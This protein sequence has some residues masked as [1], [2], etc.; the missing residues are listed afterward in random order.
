MATKNITPNQVNDI[1]KSKGSRTPSHYRDG[2]AKTERSVAAVVNAAS[3]V[4]SVVAKNLY[5]SSVT[6]EVYQRSM[7]ADGTLPSSNIADKL[8]YM[9]G[10]Y[11]TKKS[12]SLVYVSHKLEEHSPFRL[13]CNPEGTDTTEMTTDTL[14][15]IG[16]PPATTFMPVFQD[17]VKLS[18]SPGYLQYNKTSDPVALFDRLCMDAIKTGVWYEDHYCTLSAPYPLRDIERFTTSINT[19]YAS[20]KPTYNFFVPEYENSISSETLTEA[21]LPN[22]YVML[23][24]MLKDET[25]EDN[26]WFQRHIT[27]NNSLRVETQGE[28]LRPRSER[29]KWDIDDS[30]AVQYFDM[31]GRQVNDV[32]SDSDRINLGAK[33]SNLFV[34]H[35]N[36][37]LLKN[38]NSSKELFPM[39]TDIEFSTDTTTEFAQA[40]KDSGMGSHLMS[41]ISS[42]GLSIKHYVEEVKTSMQVASDEV[43]ANE[44]ISRSEFLDTKRRTFDVSDWYDS[45]SSRTKD[46]VPAGFFE[47]KEHVFLGKADPTVEVTDDPKYDLFRS[48]MSVVFTSK[49]RDLVRLRTRT[50]KEMMRGEPAHTETVLYR[51]EKRAGTQSGQVLQNFW[52]PN[53]NEIEVHKFVDTQVKYGRNYTYTIYAYELVFGSKYKYQ[54]YWSRDGESGFIV[55]TE[56]SLRIVEVPYFSYTNRLLDSPPVMPDVE[57][58]P[59]RS[60]PDRIKIN[61]SGNVGRYDLMPEV[62]ERGEER[63]HKLTRRAQD[64]LDDEPIRYESDDHAMEFQVFRSTT[65]PHGYSDFHGKMV[66]TVLTDIDPDTMSKATSASC[67]DEISPNKKYWYT[68]RSVDNHGHVSYPS[69]VYQVEMIDDHGSIYPIIKTVDFAPRTPKISAKQMKRIMQIVPT[70]AQGILNEEKSNLSDAVTVSDRWDKDTLFLGVEDESLWGKKFKIRLTSRQTGRKIDINVVFEHRHLKIQPE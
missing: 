63:I 52:L 1:L 40:L 62:I 30:L 32:L 20:V 51:I 64:R 2:A 31:Y 56:P 15:Q 48:L 28:M 49:V 23:T 53:S 38:Y 36:V 8:R 7:Y 11:W 57:I 45:V 34:S 26:E 59:F 22:M 24:E 69:P 29:K 42:S 35:T 46:N 37:E 14:R 33:F 6:A 4:R 41:S 21:V 3:K 60:V 12:D 18:P 25:E 10:N 58:I 65:H 50:Y 39:F 5:D 44:V 43:Q 47:S 55:R 67:M 17:V 61:F 16:A 70:F 66:K 9:T 13:S 54:D 27:L 19:M 68:F